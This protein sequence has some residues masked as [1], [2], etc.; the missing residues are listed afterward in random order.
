[1]L[2]KIMKIL[3][4]VLQ[5]M[6]NSA[7]FIAILHRNSGKLSR[8]IRPVHVWSIVLAFSQKRSQCILGSFGG[9]KYIVTG[10]EYVKE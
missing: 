5:N 4:N 3:A 1:M 2:G 9:T 8:S 7:Y 10:V 6:L